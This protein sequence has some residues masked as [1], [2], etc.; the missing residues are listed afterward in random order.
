MKILFASHSSGLAG[1]EQS[2]LHLVREAASRGHTGVVVLPDHGPLVTEIQNVPGSFEVLIRRNRLWMGRRYSPVVGTVRTLQA[3][4][5][6]PGYVTLIRSGGYDVVVVNSS[7]SP[8]P[9]MAARILGIPVLQ[10]IRESLISN[11]MIKSALPKSLIRRLIA[12]WASRVIC[13]SDFVAC[14]YGYPNRV[15]YPQVSKRFLDFSDN[16]MT[17]GRKPHRAVMCGTVSPEKGQLDAIRAI[18]VAKDLGT[19]IS[20]EIFGHGKPQDVDDVKSLIRELQLSDCV[21]YRGPVSDMISVYTGAD[22]ALVCSRNEGF[23][24]VTAEAIL[25]GRPV[26]AYGVGGT[27]EILEYG[28]GISTAVSAEDMGAALH[29]IS[30]EPLL[31][32]ALCR[33]ARRSE[34]RTKLNATAQDVIRCV[35]DLAQ[36]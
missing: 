8:V 6:V 5:D 15:I 9:L 24:K 3:A 10:L 13:I 2:L 23:G 31:F 22:F 26:I 30:T 32:E 28:G 29:R 4:L 14:Q 11:P 33:E 17:F 16:S 35:E 7:V 36:A 21:K 20:L 19:D 12:S 34:I 25:V 18:K 1:A 27:V